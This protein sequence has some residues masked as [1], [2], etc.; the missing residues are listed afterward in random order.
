MI[1]DQPGDDSKLLADAIRI[2]IRRVGEGVFGNEVGKSSCHHQTRYRSG[3]QRNRLRDLTG[4]ATRL[5]FNL[6]VYTA[7]LVLCF[8]S[9]IDQIGLRTAEC[10][11]V[12]GGSAGSKARHLKSALF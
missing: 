12:R 6:E 4:E 1:V 9:Q 5:L 2:A 10:D 11:A 8:I 3:L 7:E